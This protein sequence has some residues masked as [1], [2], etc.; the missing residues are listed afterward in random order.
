MSGV[1]VFSASLR[2]C[3]SATLRYSART[4]AIVAARVSGDRSEDDADGSARVVDVHGLRARVARMDL[5]RGMDAARRRAADEKGDVVARVLAAGIGDLSF[6]SHPRSAYQGDGETCV[7]DP[8]HVQ[9]KRVLLQ[10][11]QGR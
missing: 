9:M 5:H 2:S 1:R 7:T 10:A 3:T 8:G 11:K 6:S 4:A